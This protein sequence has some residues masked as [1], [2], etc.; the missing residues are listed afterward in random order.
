M[1][2]IKNKNQYEVGEK[3]KTTVIHDSCAGFF[4][5]GTI[6]TVTGISE[7]G[8][9]IKDDEGNCVTEIGWVI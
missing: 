9:D 8:Y 7:R 2:Y 1:A 6:V 3:V 4:E 5:I